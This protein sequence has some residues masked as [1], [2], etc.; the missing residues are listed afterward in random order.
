MLVIE[1]QM[2][3]RDKSRGAGS[4]SLPSPLL[5]GGDG[6]KFHVQ[7]SPRAEEEEERRAAVHRPS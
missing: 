7:F 4:S 2:A 6:D 1:I 5:Y 3:A